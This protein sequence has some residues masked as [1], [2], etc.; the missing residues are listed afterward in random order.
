[1]ASASGLR[2]AEGVGIANV[3]DTRALS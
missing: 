3:A 1:M 2:G